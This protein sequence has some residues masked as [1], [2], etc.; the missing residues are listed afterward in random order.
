M[1]TKT[2]CSLTHS[3]HASFD[4]ITYQPTAG[5][6]IAVHASQIALD[7]LGIVDDVG[8]AVSYA[9]PRRHAGNPDLC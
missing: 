6:G 1:W 5:K 2:M 7:A 8:Q 4:R 9:M 3:F